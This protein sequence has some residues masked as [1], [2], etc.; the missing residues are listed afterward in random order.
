[1]ARIR[2][3]IAEVAP[4]DS[5]ERYRALGVEVIAGRA[6]LLDPW[7]VEAAGRR[8][9]TRRIVVATGA[10]PYLPPI[11]GLAEAAPLTS[12]TLWSLGELPERLLVLGG[13]AVGC[14][15]AQAFAR[16]GAQATLV[17]VS[18]PPA[19]ARGR[20]NVAKPCRPLSPPTASTS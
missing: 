9:T 16:L 20:R 19:A 10:E 17:E 8:L 4:H 3:V 12:E 18:A 11:P 5:A 15:L 14:E 6:R 7:T 13:G 1:M 2:A